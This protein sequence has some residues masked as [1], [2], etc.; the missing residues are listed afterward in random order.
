[1]NATLRN[2]KHSWIVLKKELMDVL[3]D[4]AAITGLALQSILSPVIWVAI[5]LIAADRMAQSNLVLPVAGGDN[6]PALVDWLDAQIDVEIVP[7]P[8]DPA[9]AVR[10]GTRDVVLVIP[11]DFAARI[12]DGL[13]APVELVTDESAGASRRAADRV[14][15]VVE[16]YGA[17]LTFLR[18]M[19]RGVAP[20]VAAPLRLDTTD[21]SPPGRSQGGLSIFVT[22]L[23]LWTALFGG[24]GI[25]ADATLGERER[26]SLEPLLLNPVSRS[27]LIAGKWLA[28]AALACAWVFAAGVTTLIV[29][30]VIPWHEYGLQVSSSDQDLL[31]VTFSM[32]PVALFWC[33]LV[34]LVSTASRTQ[35]QAQTRFGLLFMAVVLT[36]MASFLFSLENVPWLG[37]VPI[38]GQLT[39]SAD[40]LGG[41]HP[42][43]YRYIVTA[44]GSVVLALA[45]VAATARLLRRETIVFRT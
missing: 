25:A 22:M 26:G 5:T 3:R 41:G 15:G 20:D 31:A 44:A 1:M 11:A 9:G 10:D 37:A 21:V 24:V 19:A 36:T 33:A 4:R 42:A 45:L 6:A 8:A 12:A 18:L 28:A 32:F 35:Q 7:A 2:L 14:R 39:L 23:L 17:E 34:T 40:V 43:V 27:A 29:L 16:R 38:I 30:R 13:V